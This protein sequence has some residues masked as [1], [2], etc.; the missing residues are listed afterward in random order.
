MIGSRSLRCSSSVNDSLFRRLDGSLLGKLCSAMLVNGL[1]RLGRK[2]LM[3]SGS[4][5]IC[6]ASSA[7]VIFW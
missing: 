6:V 2:T 3:S 4:R 1:S 5:G 7:L